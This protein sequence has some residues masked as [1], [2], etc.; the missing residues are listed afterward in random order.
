MKTNYDVAGNWA[1]AVVCP[2]RN[3]YFSCLCAKDEKP[4]LALQ[5]V[6]HKRTNNL[7]VDGRHFDLYVESESR[8]SV[9]PSI[10]AMSPSGIRPVFGCM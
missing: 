8:R 10:L 4:L 9:S 1:V 5:I 3:P 7:V 2:C 6:V